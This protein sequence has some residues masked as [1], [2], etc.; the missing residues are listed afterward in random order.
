MSS[1]SSSSSS[2]CSD[3][4]LDVS[5][6]KITMEEIIKHASE[7]PDGFGILPPEFRGPEF[8]ITP[9]PL[10]AQMSLSVPQTTSLRLVLTT[11]LL[12]TNDMVRKNLDKDLIQRMVEAN[13][14]LSMVIDERT[15]DDEEEEEDDE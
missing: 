3:S 13:K 10:L 2:D 15:N 12:I 14:Q 1:S 7:A 6:L 5:D 8:S 11:Y 4:K 9:A